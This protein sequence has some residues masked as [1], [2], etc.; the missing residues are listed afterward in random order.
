MRVEGLKLFY[1]V[2]PF[3]GL[4]EAGVDDGRLDPLG[5]QVFGDFEG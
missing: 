2:T 4:G 5:G 1:V 3:E